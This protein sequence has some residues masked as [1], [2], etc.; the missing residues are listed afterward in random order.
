MPAIFR[1]ADGV[2]RMLSRVLAVVACAALAFC[3]A[4][5]V[6]EILLRAAFSTS[7]YL[8]AELVGYAVA[9]TTFF[10]L[11]YTFRQGEHIRAS[12][13]IDRLAG[14]PRRAAEV[15]CGV[16]ALAFA[17]FAAWYLF[18][19]L[20]RY[21]DRGTAADSGSGILLWWPYAAL[22]VGMVVLCLEILMY[23]LRLLLGGPAM[24]G[25]ASIEGFVPD[26]PPAGERHGG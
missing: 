8:G 18:G 14:L 15:A 1:I 9:V 25:G 24:K 6:L 12:V 19:T 13:L 21:W 26:E 7:T 16:V 10:A 4:M 3:G 23:V 11:P 2:V 22:V 20:L 17:G 5:I